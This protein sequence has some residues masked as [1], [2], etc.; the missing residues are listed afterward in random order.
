MKN[1][2]KTLVLGLTVTVFASMLPTTAAYAS[3]NKDVI[4][5]DCED[6]DSIIM[7]DAAGTCT[8]VNGT[9]TIEYDNAPI[10]S[11]YTK[12]DQ[13]KV[14]N[15]QHVEPGDTVGIEST[16]FG[17]YKECTANSSAGN[18]GISTDLIYK[19]KSYR[20]EIADY[21]CEFVGNPYVWGGTSL[22]NGADCSGF[23]QTLFDIWGINTP[24]CA[25]EQYFAAEH[26]TEDELEKGDLIFYGSDIHNIKHVAIY[27]GD[28][29]IVHAK[30]KNYGIVIDDDY[31]YNNIA[32]FGRY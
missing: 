19:E 23:V 16:E 28:G 6:E 21:A 10:R 24:R 18:M 15:N 30:G 1:I 20:E 11:I 31:K 7:A 17:Y 2:V 27:L 3:N 4:I 13:I 8:I 5:V 14:I 22:T 25:D 12:L 32:G 9:L 26:I 29:K